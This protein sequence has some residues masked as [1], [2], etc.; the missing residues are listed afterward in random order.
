MWRAVL[1]TVTILSLS[2]ALWAQDGKNSA[3]GA[4]RSPAEKKVLENPNDVQA[5]TAY[6]NEVMLN[7]SRTMTSDPKAARQKLDDMEAFVA[8]LK[9]DQ[10]AAKARVTGMKSIFQS[11]RSRL[12]VQNVA[13]ADLE[14]TLLGN[15]DDAKAV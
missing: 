13:L 1:A 6:L 3:E 15:P 7:V 11:Y 9:I 4:T 2:S 14:K 12:D 10:P 5:L 8:E